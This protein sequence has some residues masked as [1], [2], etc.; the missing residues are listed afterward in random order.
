MKMVEFNNLIR[1]EL[2][3]KITIG[4]EHSGKAF[5]CPTHG[6]RDKVITK[7]AN[8]DCFGFYNEFIHVCK[9]CGKVCESKKF[10]TEKIIEKI[11][12]SK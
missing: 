7:G 8:N 9:E 2:G 5:Y 10:N 3:E 1:K 4:F 12:I 11:L 6:F